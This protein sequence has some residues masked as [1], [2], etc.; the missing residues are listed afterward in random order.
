MKIYTKNT[1]PWPSSRIRCRLARPPK[2]YG[3]EEPWC[4]I[5]S[6]ARA[7]TH[8]VVVGCSGLLVA[9]GVR[10]VGCIPEHHRPCAT[11]IGGTISYSLSVSTR[12]VDDHPHTGTKVEKQDATDEQQT[13]WRHRPPPILGV[14]SWTSQS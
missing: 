12:D 4:R 6:I 2:A 13:P 1:C 14:V 5:A 11:I 7:R 3:G 8:G 10:G 9:G